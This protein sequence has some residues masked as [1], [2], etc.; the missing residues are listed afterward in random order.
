MFI[1]IAL[2]KITELVKREDFIKIS[3]VD[4][5]N[6]SIIFTNRACNVSSSGNVTWNNVEEHTND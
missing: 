1:R 3:F 6:I 2:V 4:G 5:D